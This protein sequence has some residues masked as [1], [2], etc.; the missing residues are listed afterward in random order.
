MEDNNKKCSF[1]EH[2]ENDAVYY[3]CDCKVYI[4]NKCY[5]SH[6][7]FL[8]NHSILNLDN[9][10]EIFIDLC[11]EK[12]HLKKLEFYCKNHN[13]LCCAACITKIEAKG[14]GQHKNCDICII[15]DIKEEKKNKLKENIKYIEELSKNFDN[16]IHELKLLFD[17]ID[18]QKDKLKSEI[19]NIFTKIRTALN[20]REDELLL[21]VNKKFDEKF[22]NED[23]IK[24][25]EKLPNKIKLS[26]EKGKLI[27]NEWNDNNK[28]SSIINSCI[29]IEDN[30]KNINIIND[31]IKK[32]KNNNDSNIEF[33]IQQEY[34]NNLINSIKS[35]GKISDKYDIDS[36]ILKN[37]DDIN[38]FYN[39]LSNKIK[40]NNMK[41]L[42]RAN[43]DG[44][45]L[46]NLNKKINNKSNLIFLFL[47][48]NI[49]IFGAFIK[50][51]INVVH[52][53]YTKDKDAFVFSLNNN[54]IYEVLIPDYAIRFYDNFPILVGNNANTNGF[55]IVSRNFQEYSLTNPKIY[56]FQ[57]N[58]ELT[59]NYKELSE[60][61]VFEI[62]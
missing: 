13:Q 41:L 48:G 46:D 60:F 15:E 1:K 58:N 54:K 43:R 34:F 25:G 29:N 57:K 2:K 49:R 39:L 28:L 44:L 9:K 50:E 4:C 21:E 31:N 53:S 20:E 18:E 8:E 17:K 61:E 52:D 45:K 59:E 37:K 26:L 10:K 22:G 56:N 30:I 32:C 5:N 14:Y 24:E 27:D 38:K 47:T 42:Y 11:K 6:Q 19:Q 12:N 3:C 62:N 51:K 35:L 40:I 36:L 7:S 55:W 33:N 16:T 23:I